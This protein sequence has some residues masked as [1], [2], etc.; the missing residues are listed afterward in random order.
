MT[1]L[2]TVNQLEEE[3]GVTPRAI[4]FYEV[5]GLLSPRRA[6]TTRV[7]GRRDRA[8]LLLVLRGKRLGFSLA[9]IKELLDLYHV[10]RTGNQQLRELLRRSRLHIDDLE[11]KKRDLD[12]HIGEWRRQGLRIGFTNGCFDILHPGHVRVL[13]AARRACDR[14][15][16]GLNRDASVRRLKGEDRP[17]QDER[18]RAEVLAALEAVDLVVV[19]EDD[20]PIRL[21]E[22]VRPSVLVKGGE[23]TREQVVGHEF[24]EAHGGEVMLVDILDGHSTTSLVKRAREGRA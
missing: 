12:A 2:F 23:Y 7:F 11:R 10:D 3:L 21:I 19:F 16:V 22:Q 8:R 4:R 9:E 5:K 18:A 6:G 20:T 1:E 13:S 24:V 14:L 15:V 17:V